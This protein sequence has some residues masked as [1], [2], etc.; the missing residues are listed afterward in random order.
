MSIGSEFA[1]FSY[2]LTG[3][4]YPNGVSEAFTHDA[5]GQVLSHVT[6]GVLPSEDGN[7]QGSGPVP[8][9]RSYE[10]DAN[11]NVTGEE[12]SGYGTRPS[13]LWQEETVM[14]EGT[15]KNSCSIS[16]FHSLGISR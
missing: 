6:A 5:G 15:F 2:R 8:I 11:G 1:S 13:A 3:M 4:A 12:S 16:C 14:W 9:T 7:S 10:H